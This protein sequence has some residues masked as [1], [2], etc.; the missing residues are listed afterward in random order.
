MIARVE[1]AFDVADEHE[2]A[3]GRDHERQKR[4]RHH[5]EDIEKGKRQGEPAPGPELDHRRPKSLTRHRG[6]GAARH[7]T[8]LQPD[9][10]RRD[11]HQNDRD[12]GGRIVE[13]R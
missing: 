13:R 4:Q 7:D 6:E 3:E 1:Q 8:V 11:H 10:Q 9:Q 5:D 12:R 2:L